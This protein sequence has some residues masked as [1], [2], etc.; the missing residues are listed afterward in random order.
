MNCLKKL[1]QKLTKDWR[2]FNAKV[3]LGLGLRFCKVRRVGYN[4]N[5]NGIIS[6]RSFPN[7]VDFHIE[8]SYT[9]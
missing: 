8:R 7:I 5:F 1:E 3:R 9:V 4:G 2:L 6:N